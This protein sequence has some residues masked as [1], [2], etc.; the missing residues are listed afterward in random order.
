MI[1]T[2]VIKAIRACNLRCTYCYYINEDTKDYG[3]VIQ[4]QT[5]ERLYSH[6]AEYL[7]DKHGFTFV[8][9]GGEPLM[10]GRKRF[11]SYLDLQAKYFSPGSVNNCVQTNGVL[12]DQ[13]WIDF[14]KV[15]SVGVGISI[16]SSPQ[17]HDK[18]RVTIRGAGTYDKVVQ[19]IEL[20]RANDMPV[21]TLAVVDG[22]F[23]G[24]K[25]LDSVE[26]LGIPACDFLIPMSNNALENS[27]NCEDY[28]SHTDFT[29]I[30]AFLASA[31]RRWSTHPKPEFTVRLF[32]CVIR[33][34][35]GFDS[36]Y[37]DAGSVNLADFLVLETDGALCLDPDFWHIDRYDLGCHYKLNFNVGD[38]DFNLHAVESRMAAFTV[39]NHLETLPDACQQC[40]V[41]SL[42]RG[43][44]PASRFGPDG[45]FNHRSAYCEAMYALCDSVVDYI[46]SKGLTEHLCDD[47][48]KRHLGRQ[49]A[50]AA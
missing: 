7:G 31:F 39:E 47:D 28:R 45:S 1:S 33:N 6:V 18:N 15:N 5:L 10:L 48:L 42:C 3:K 22:N 27:A 17:A 16:D 46:D 12:I 30:G 19:A 50:T 35:F 37:L 38:E 26:R 23:D 8:W 36:G 43:S 32:E 4:P 13:P 34:A 29:K 25:A 24:G 49:A 44:H 11:Q 21:G 40:K 2:I 41:R 9:H 20:L 14:F